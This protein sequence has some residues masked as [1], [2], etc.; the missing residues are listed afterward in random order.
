MTIEEA[1]AQ[2]ISIGEH[3]ADMTEEKGDIWDM[4]CEALDM[5]IK[6]LKEDAEN[7][8]YGSELGRLA[9]EHER[10]EKMWKENHHD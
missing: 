3:C 5:A 8:K 1:I 10:L 4:D 2:L 6:A 7:K 9:A